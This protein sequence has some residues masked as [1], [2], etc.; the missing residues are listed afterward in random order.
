VS[1]CCER[2][3]DCCNGQCCGFGEICCWATNSCQRRDAVCGPH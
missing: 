3:M 2:G 1:T